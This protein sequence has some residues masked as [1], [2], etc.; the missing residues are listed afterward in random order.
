MPLKHILSIFI[1][2]LIGFSAFSQGSIIDDSTK[3]VYGLGSTGFLYEKNYLRNDTT[4]LHPDSLLGIFQL[5]DRVR[6]QEW[7]WQDL[8]NEGTA[9]KPYYPSLPHTIATQNGFNSFHLYAPIKDSIK[10]F[11]TRSPYTN[12]FYNQSNVGLLKVGFT[13][14]QNVTPLLNFALD[15]NRITTSKQ[16]SAT[17]SEDRLVDHWDYTFS[18]NYNSANRKYTLLAAWIHFNHKQN[19]QGGIDISDSYNTP[20]SLL[21]ADY[22]SFYNERLTSVEGRERWNDLHIYQ[23]FRMS[24]GFQVYN[25]F[26]YQRHKNF[27]TDLGYASNY[28]P[29]VYADTTSL[30]SLKTYYQYNV[31]QNEIGLK[32][33]YKGFRYVAGFQPRYYSNDAKG[34]NLSQNNLELITKLDLSYDFADSVSFLSGKAMLG[35]RGYMVDADVVYRGIQ[36]GFHNSVSPVPLIFQNYR[37]DLLSWENDFAAPF[38]TSLDFRLPISLKKIKF[39]AGAQ[40]MTISNYLYFD[41]N[42]IATQSSDAKEILKIDA[43]FQYR[44]KWLK[45]RHKTIFSTNDDNEI[46]AIPQ[47]VNNSNLEFKLTYAKVLDLY[48]GFNVYHRSQ[49]KAMAYSPLLQSFY[50][51][52]TNEV[53]GLPVV[54]AYVNFMV[55]KVKVAL[56]FD[57]LNK[58]FPTNGYYTT[59]GYLGLGRAFHIKVNWPLFD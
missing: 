6:Q 16:F 51:Q 29:F 28:D 42:Q 35:T 33:I 12:M 23:Q 32:G 20:T 5:T 49:Y 4:L 58:G 31:I 50:V 18:S 56:S 38:I 37:S 2:S 46:L 17:T 27:Y 10:Y 47:W 59:P 52:S 36:I 26:D 15:V 30:D 44:N 54:D 57:Y 34:F 40:F 39:E 55:K 3:Q 9:S 48:F 21:N 24:N 13:H 1:F 14:S 19:E 25:S 41:Q 11:N 7:L 53:W 43:M 22:N 8:G 45:F